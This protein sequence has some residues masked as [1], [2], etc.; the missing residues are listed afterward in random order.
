MTASTHLIRQMGHVA[1]AVPDPELSAQDLVDL[2]GLKVTGRDADTVYLSSNTRVNEISYRRAPQ[3]GVIAVGL[4]ALD[5][6]AVDEVTRRARA[7]GLEILDDRPLDPRCAR[8][9]RFVAPF[10]IVLEVHSPV[11]RSAAQR[12]IG[13]GSRPRRI[14]H[15]NFKA[16]DPLA[17]RDTFHSVLGMRM[18]D[19]TEGNEFL[20]FRAHDGHHH[21]VAVFGGEP[22]LHHY[23]F[24]FHSMEDLAKIADS[25][26]LKRRKLLWG[27]GRHGAGGNIF[28]YYVDPNHCVVEMSVEMDRIDL[29]ETWEARAWT[30]SP[31]LADEWINLWGSPP[32]ANF[33]DPGLPFVD[34]PAA[35]TTGV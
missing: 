31:S 34:V 19:R 15:V 8:A 14:E 12:H 7:A 4:E 16:P 29:D 35:V 1:F 22:G 23:A 10:G 28:Q 26:V 18:S 32:P 20:W 33:T 11:P 24:D 3:A 25:L 27:P 30:F 2:V 9:V 5:E 6:A 21:T 17:M 13:S